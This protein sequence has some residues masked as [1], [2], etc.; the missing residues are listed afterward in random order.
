MTF[1]VRTF[2][3][4]FEKRKERKGKE[5]FLTMPQKGVCLAY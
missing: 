1:I 2:D 4:S 3:F 5:V